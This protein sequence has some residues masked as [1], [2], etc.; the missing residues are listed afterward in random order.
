[1]M[2]KHKKDNLDPSRQVRAEA[3][4]KIDIIQD[5]PAFNLKAQAI[6]FQHGVFIDDDLY[7][8][9]LLFVRSCYIFSQLL[10]N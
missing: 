1:M 3:D 6:C 10:S 8:V 5:F 4:I 9:K 2:K 7:N